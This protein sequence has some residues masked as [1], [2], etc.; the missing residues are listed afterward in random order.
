MLNVKRCSF[1]SKK[2]SFNK[3]SIDPQE[4]VKSWQ[5]KEIWQKEKMN[6]LVE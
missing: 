2:R 1:K 4:R 3:A 5:S 6:D